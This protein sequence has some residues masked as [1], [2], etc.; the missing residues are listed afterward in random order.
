[1]EMHVNNGIVDEAEMRR[2]AGLR[3][4]VKA[5]FYAHAGLYVLV[6][7]LLLAI[8]ALTGPIWWFYWALF[9]W[10]I[11]LV[12]HGFS[13]FA[14]SGAKPLL[15]RMEEREYQKLVKTEG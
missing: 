6:N 15:R 12:A 13:V 3:A 1:M 10:G 11:G 9:G 8:D 2:R 14:P 7:L 5:S 4:K